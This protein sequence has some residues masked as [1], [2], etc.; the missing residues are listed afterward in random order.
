[1]IYLGLLFK[2]QLQHGCSEQA[3]CSGDN[4]PLL[5]ARRCLNPRNASVLLA[6][7]HL[8]ASSISGMLPWA[9][10]TVKSYWSKR[11]RSNVTEIARVFKERAESLPLPAFKNVF[12][13]KLSSEVLHLFHVELPETFSPLRH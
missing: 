12:Y 5:V 2:A 6:P 11:E 8:N 4:Q 9:A 13:S 7:K 1:M 3:E 10:E